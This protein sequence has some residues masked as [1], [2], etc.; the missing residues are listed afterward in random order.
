ME[1][2]KAVRTPL[3]VNSKLL[4]LTEEEYTLEAQSMTEVPYKQIVGLL[5]YVMIATQSDLA[6]PISCV[7]Q[8][9]ARPGS[10]H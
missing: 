7:S 5:I 3:D 1:D 8:D 4:K 9:M 6:Y 10:M 2:C